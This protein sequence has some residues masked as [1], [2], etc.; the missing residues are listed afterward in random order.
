MS[1][2]IHQFSHLE[3]PKDS[4]LAA[5][6]D[7]GRLSLWPGGVGSGSGIT[8]TVEEWTRLSIAANEVIRQANLE[9]LSGYVA[10]EGNGVD[11]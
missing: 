1:V 5:I 9:H 10:C 11:S 8:M 4:P 6:T 3:M 2:T 7:D